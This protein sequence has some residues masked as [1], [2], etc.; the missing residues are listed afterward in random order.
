MCTRS[1]LTF[2]FLLTLLSLLFFTNHLPYSGNQGSVWSKISTLNTREWKDSKSGKKVTNEPATEQEKA[3]GEKMRH[4]AIEAVKIELGEEE[5]K[6]FVEL[7]KS[8]G[9]GRGNQFGM[10]GGGGMFGGGNT[11][12]TGNTGFG[13]TTGGLNEV[14]QRTGSSQSGGSSFVI[15]NLIEN[16]KGEDAEFDYLDNTI[17]V[18]EIQLLMEAATAATDAASTAGMT[19]MLKKRLN[20]WIFTDSTKETTESKKY[21]S[22]LVDVQDIQEFLIRENPIPGIRFS[23]S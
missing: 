21:F 16:Y 14:L 8:G 7:Q 2:I 10:N 20:Q 19:K 22:E 13:A 3:A 17:M 9:S 11:G 12:N 15:L 4:E 1:V 18:R 6:N 23:M 5:S